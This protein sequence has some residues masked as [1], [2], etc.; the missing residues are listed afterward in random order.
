MRSHASG[1]RDQP[2]VVTEARQSRSAEIAQRE[3]RYL[4]MMGIRVVCFIVTV[5]LF[6]N[7]VGWPAI[8]PAIGAISLPY[9]AVVVANAR[10]Q[11]GPSSGFRPYEPYLPERYVPPNG[12][13]PDGGDDRH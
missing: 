11:T 6:L 2:V 4:V 13:G 12:D 7:H 8:I 3:R 10:R 1:H 5:V 9:F